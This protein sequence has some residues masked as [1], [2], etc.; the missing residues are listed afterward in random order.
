[1]DICFIGCD[2]RDFVRARAPEAFASGPIERADGTVIGRH[3]GVGGLTVGQRAGVG[4]ATGARPYV[5]RLE[6]P[7]GAA[8]VGARAQPPPRAEAPPARQLTADL[9]PPG[10]LPPCARRSSWAAWR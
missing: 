5:L 3:A 10:H 8:A 6:P 7:P 4:V 2:Y 9:P 1:M